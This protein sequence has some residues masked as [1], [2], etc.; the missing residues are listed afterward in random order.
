MKKSVIVII[1][2]VISF[3]VTACGGGGP[4]NPSG[5]PSSVL[6]VE[7]WESYPVGDFPGGGWWDTPV[8]YSVK[9]V[10]IPAN[11]KMML[12]GPSAE[13]S[14]DAGGIY[15]EFKIGTMKP[16]YISY[17]MHP[18]SYDPVNK[19]LPYSSI[20]HFSLIGTNDDSNLYNVR[21]EGVEI[22][23]VQYEYGLGSIVANRVEILGN[24]S[25]P[26][27][28][29][30]SFLFELKNID[31]NSG[32]NIT[33]D[34]WINGVEVESCI[35]FLRPIQAIHV[36]KFHNK[37]YGR[38]HFD[39]IYMADLPLEYNCPV[40]SEDPPSMPL[41]PQ[42]S[43]T[44]PKDPVLFIFEFNAFCR[45][46]P[47]TN[48]PKISTYPEG[49]QLEVNGQNIAGSWWW[50]DGAGCWTADT[51]GELVGD[52]TTLDI[53]I[54]P[55]P[56]EDTDTSDG[57]PGKPGGCKKNLGQDACIEEGGTWDDQPGQ[58]GTC[59]CP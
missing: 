10:E 13:I 56:P 18:Y 24:Q 2:L 51:V 17:K 5:Y 27:L 40:V 29:D 37:N 49:T 3:G 36:V 4:H 57:S 45:S 33:F 21:S 43:P 1:L 15:Y 52:I 22:H 35:K 47:G 58:P 46:G 59:V 44:E 32:E 11:H 8:F 26:L 31:W 38:V 16:S 25:N 20:G 30:N 34:L 7:T 28:I 9:R 39:N 54:H 12:E 53:I 50:S 41:P 19:G 48:Y 23:F 55:P 14:S 42:P 6:F